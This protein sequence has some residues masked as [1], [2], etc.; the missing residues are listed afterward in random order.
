MEGEKENMCKKAVVILTSEFSTATPKIETV[1]ERF[2]VLKE[3]SLENTESHPN[4]NFK[5]AW[6][7]HSL[8]YTVTT[9]NVSELNLLVKNIKIDRLKIILYTTHEGQTNIQTLKLNGWNEHARRTP[10]KRKLG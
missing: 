3:S 4:W 8:I 5:R 1:G 7:K 10:T 2:S 6:Q 9:V